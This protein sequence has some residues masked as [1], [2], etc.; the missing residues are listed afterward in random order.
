MKKYTVIFL[1]VAL[2]AVFVGTAMANEWNLYGNARVATFYTSR[3]YKDV[4]PD[5]D[6]FGRS[7]LKNTEWGLQ[8]NSRIGATVKGDMLEARFELGIGSNTVINR[9]LYG[10][11]KFTEGWGLKVGQDYTPITFFLSGQVFDGDAGLLQVGNAYGSRKGQIALEGQVGP[12]M[13]KFAAI[14]QNIGDANFLSIDPVTDVVTVLQTSTESYIPKLEASYQMNFADGMSG[15]VFGGY[16][17]IKYY[18]NNPVT[19]DDSSETITSY[20]L[21][22]GADLNFGP[23]FVKPQ[24][25]YYKNGGAAGWLGL[26]LANLTRG[27]PSVAVGDFDE[28]NVP[29]VVNGSAQNINTYTAMLAL[30][31]SP[32]EQLTLE[33]GIGWAYTDFDDGFEVDKNTYLEYYL[34]AV[35]QMAPGVFLIPEVGYRDFGKAKFNEA[36]VSDVDLGSLFYLGAKWQINF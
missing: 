13:L 26:G 36:G 31:F 17:S 35:Y 12:G 4:F 28:F 6:A 21:G 22:L 3:D 29:R 23:M 24:F 33:G 25:S 30:G 20:V 10:V 15:H 19:D 18:A 5:D 7:S 32:T 2:A 34:Q 27:L 14:Q 9:R 1:A 11:W 16:Q 8:S